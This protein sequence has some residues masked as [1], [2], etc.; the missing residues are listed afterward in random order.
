MTLLSRGGLASAL[1]LGLALVACTDDGESSEPVAPSATSMT[2]A[3]AVAPAE[4]TATLAPATETSAGATA[5]ST[6]T[7]VPA[8]AAVTT[9]EDDTT[10]RPTTTPHP[11][12]VAPAT[13][14]SAPP[15]TDPRPLYDACV[16]HDGRLR[17]WIEHAPVDGS[18]P[19]PLVIDLHG[20]T[21]E[22]RGQRR[23]SGF[24]ALAD[25]EGF[26]VVWPEGVDRSWSAGGC[27]GAQ[28]ADDVGFLRRLIDDVAS[29][30]PV[31]RVFV[32]GLSNGC[33]M[34][35]RFAAEA[36]DVVDAAA[37]MSFYLLSEPDADYTPVPVL[38]I[39]GTAD[40]VVPY[41]DRSVFGGAVGNF[42]RWAAL[43]GCTGEIERPLADAA[44][45]ELIGTG[46]DAAVVLVT[47]DATGHV[48]YRGLDTD[49]E[50]TELAWRFMND[51]NS[52]P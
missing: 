32:T 17:C 50:T 39:H 48:P 49:V 8:T 51:P 36:S 9:V 37:C 4:S 40:P 5:T 42:E 52:F 2:E 21:G 6:P 3:T 46:C 41:E 16:D 34:A 12:T 19:T 35:Q 29:R 47:L 24:E 10:D 38:E 14:A 43:N 7:T 27:C 15:T 18:M 25:S 31:D 33:A 23:A 45:T 28:S 1:V 26:V 30:H 11:L 22:A 20:F 44:G 13:P